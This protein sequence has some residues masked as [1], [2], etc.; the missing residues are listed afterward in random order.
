MEFWGNWQHLEHFEQ[1]ELLLSEEGWALS[2][3]ESVGKHREHHKLVTSSHH[4]LTHLTGKVLSFC[5]LPMPRRGCVS[6]PISKLQ[7]CCV[8]CPHPSA[9]CVLFTNSGSGMKSACE[10]VCKG[11]QPAIVTREKLSVLILF[12]SWVDHIWAST[13]QFRKASIQCIQWHLQL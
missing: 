5:I 2:E 12:I 9:M 8:S 11:H 10:L 4:P 1:M 13:C 6:V 3:L 7:P